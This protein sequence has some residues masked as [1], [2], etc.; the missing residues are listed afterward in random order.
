MNS[1]ETP[2]KPRESNMVLSLLTR[3]NFILRCVTLLPLAHNP[4]V[5]SLSARAFHE[6]CN[7]Y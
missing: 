7:S 1:E 4:L 2:S 5:S 6:C 3:D